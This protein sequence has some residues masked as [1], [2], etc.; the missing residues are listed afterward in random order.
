MGNYMGKKHQCPAKSCEKRE[1]LQ[2]QLMTSQQMESIHFHEQLEDQLRERIKELDCLYRLTNLI[3]QHEDSLDKILQE[4][5][6]LLPASW[7][8]P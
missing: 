2:A 8:Y 3:E 7:Q 6:A 4:T 5:I 1:V